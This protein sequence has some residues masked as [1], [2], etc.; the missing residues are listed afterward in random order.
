M[1]KYLFGILVLQVVTGGLFYTVLQEG[2][3]DTH[4]LLVAGL[5]DLL[6]SL[7]MA[8]WFAAMDRRSHLI[9]LDAVK[10]THA[11]EREELRVNAERQK[12]RIVNKSHKQLL[13]ETRRAHAMANFK[14][15][16]AF[17]GILVMGG[18]MVYSQFVTF[19]LLLLTTGG[20]GLAGY[21]TRMRQER[22]TRQKQAAISTARIDKGGSPGKLL[23]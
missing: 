4:F 11:R 21:L 15:G 22:M 17:T 9:E 8:F 10:E 1:L 6:F 18:I 2:L 3:E 23:K 7:L 14:I 5:L 16:A 19:G 13:K 12:S 20:G